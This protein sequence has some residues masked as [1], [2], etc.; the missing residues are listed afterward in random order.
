[1]RKLLVAVGVLAL[2]FVV[3]DRASKYFVEST[4]ADHIASTESVAG[5]DVS[6]GGFPFL[7]QVLSNHFDEVDVTLPRLDARTS[8]GSIEVQDVRVSL[9]DVETSDRF[10]K[11]TAGSATGSGFVPYGAFDHFDPITV[12]YGG[13]SPDGTAYLNVS[14]PSLGAG[15]VRVAP[16][17]A[18]GLSLNFDA[19]SVPSA[20]LPKGLRTFVSAAH[21]FGGMPD[22][23]TIKRMDATADGLRVTLAGSDVS[24]AR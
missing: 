18:N 10:S 21:D 12:D 13:T 8:A 7:T 4:L 17:V 5:A 16:S 23:L 15:T 14:A 2:L 20:A 1:M 22:G 19:L 6:I 3:A 24:I 11:A 9:R